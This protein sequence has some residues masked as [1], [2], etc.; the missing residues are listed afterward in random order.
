VWNLVLSAYL[1][2]KGFAQSAADLCI[3]FHYFNAGLVIVAVYVDD[4]CIVAGKERLEWV[5]SI[6]D[7]K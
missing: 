1:L 6:R 5:K 4:C 2:G 7:S 3:F